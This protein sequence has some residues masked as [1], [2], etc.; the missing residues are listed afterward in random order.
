MTTSTGRGDHTLAPEVL[1]QMVADYLDAN[2]TRPRLFPRR[3]C[4]VA[5]VVRIDLVGARPPIWRRLRL[6]SDLT[7]EQLHTIIQV[8]MGWA[9]EHLHIFEMRPPRGSGM[10]DRRFLTWFDLDGDDGSDFADATDSLPEWFVQ[11]CEVLNEP[12][13]TLAYE[14]D[15]GDMWEHRIRL[16]KVQTWTDDDPPARCLAGRRACPPENSGGVW[17]YQALVHR[18]GLGPDDPEPTEPSPEWL[19]EQWGWMCDEFDPAEFDVAAVN[20]SLLTEEDDFAD[21]SPF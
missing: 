4:R 10:L 2:P 7:L 12:G 16:E 9:S 15:F 20:R 3:A 14:Y 13:D 6:A 11:V 8:T 17:G 19:Q 21:H 5:Y 18:L 1:R